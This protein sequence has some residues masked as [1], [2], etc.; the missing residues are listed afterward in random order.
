MRFSKSVINAALG[1]E[2]LRDEIPPNAQR[3]SAV[4]VAADTA[5]AFKFR[6]LGV[7]ASLRCAGLGVVEYDQGKLRFIDARCVR[8][9]PSLRLSECLVNLRN[10]TEAY[11][12]EFKPDEAAFEGVFFF[13]N[14]KTALILGHA[15]G[16]MLGACGASGIPVY[17][18]SPKRVKQAVTGGGAAV[19]GQIQ[20]MMK[21]MLNLP[22]LPQEDAADALAIAITRI[23]ETGGIAAYETKQI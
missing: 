12:A 11:I 7:D 20:A 14:A 21:A 1:Q 5:A 13:Q 3:R 6:V 2:K 9:K 23:H 19:K 15:R 16:V 10:A 17:E 22:E 4:A 8:N 18:Y